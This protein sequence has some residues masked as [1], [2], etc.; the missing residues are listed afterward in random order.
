MDKA[1]IAEWILS[2]V[3]EPAQSGSVVGD[4]LETGGAHNVA[5]FWSNVFQTVAVRVW[6][7]I[8]TEPGFVAGL[9]FRGALMQT[10][11]CALGA[12]L[13]LFVTEVGFVV[14][15]KVFS[16]EFPGH[17]QIDLFFVWLNILVFII[18][19]PSYY[20]GRWIARRSTGKD[21]TLCLAMLGS[22]HLCGYGVRTLMI[23]LVWLGRHHDLLDKVQPVVWPSFWDISWPGVICSFTAYLVGVSLVRRCRQMPRTI[24]G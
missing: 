5:W 18:I 21:A 3:M 14:E 17:L 8:K 9:A 7:D 4:L 20:V 12:V 11:F 1:K 22:A 10:V 24:V 16:V 6:C 19:G 23:W 15:R 2:L 13:F